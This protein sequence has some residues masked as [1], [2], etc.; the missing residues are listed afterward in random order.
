MALD[1][2]LTGATGFVGGGLLLELLR[3]PD[4]GQVCMLNRKPFPMYTIEA[5]GV[6]IIPG[7]IKEII[8]P[9]FMNLSQIQPQLTGYAACFFCAGISSIGLKE[10]EYT[11]ITYDTTLNVAKT[12]VAQNPGMVFTYVSGRSTDSTE[13]GRTM[14]A[15]VKGRTEN[16]LAA[17][18]FR[19]VYNFRPALMLAS[20]GQQNIK[21]IYKVLGAVG[22]VFFRKSTLTL[23]Q[24][25][26]AMIHAVQRGYPKQ[27][28]EVD[29]IKILAQ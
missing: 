23:H 18:P 22:P 8:I 11:R 16:A 5:A 2:I 27:T 19:A 9:D 6:R 13:Q 3:H 1:I 12:L 24:V 10:P 15:R 7:K 4:V 14:W 20:P 29:D 17:L 28:L 21:R 26:L 25:A